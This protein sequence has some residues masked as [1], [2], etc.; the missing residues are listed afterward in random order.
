MPIR[1]LW[2][3]TCLA[4]LDGI[5]RIHVLADV[6][7]RYGPPDAISF[8]SPYVP[9]SVACYRRANTLPQPVRTLPEPDSP[10]VQLVFSSR[11]LGTM[12]W[13]SDEDPRDLVCLL[14][15]CGL[16]RALLLTC[17]GQPPE[18]VCRTRHRPGSLVRLLALEACEAVTP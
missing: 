10:I 6:W 9:P 5:D 2:V 14:E 15:E 8:A 4:V 18:G 16:P 3:S 12:Y 13:L 7:T 17:P 1:L 11:G